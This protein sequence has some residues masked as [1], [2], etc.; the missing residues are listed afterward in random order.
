MTTY[1]Y[2]E[3]ANGDYIFDNFPKNLIPLITD[4]KESQKT[5]E[6]VID[7]KKKKQE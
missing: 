7:G 3:K 6:V 4:F 2:A 5:I 1:Y